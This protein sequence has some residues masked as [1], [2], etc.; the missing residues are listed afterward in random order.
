MSKI[1]AILSLVLMTAAIAPGGTVT[2]RDGRT[3]SGEIRIEGTDLIVRGSGSPEQPDV[4]IPLANVTRAVFIDDKPA[5][6]QAVTKDLYPKPTPRKPA[7]KAAGGITAEY[8]ADAEMKDLRLTR[9]EENMVFAWPAG[10]APDPAVP[11]LFAARWSGRFTMPRYEEA[12]VRTLFV[13]VEGGGLRFWLN[14]KLEVDA[15]DRT[16]P[17]RTQYELEAGQIHEFK[18]EFRRTSAQAD[19]SVLFLMT[20][21]D[22]ET[23]RALKGWYFT[24]A[25]S[26]NTPPQV[27]VNSPLEGD[28]CSTATPLTIEA[29]AT[30]ADGTVKLVRL[31]DNGQLVATLDKPPY[32]ATVDHPKPGLHRLLALAV[33]D[34]G[35]TATSAPVTIHVPAPLG[36]LRS[37]LPAATA[38]VAMVDASGAAGRGS[39]A[40]PADAQHWSWITVAPPPTPRPLVDKRGN[41]DLDAVKAQSQAI[42][43]ASTVPAGAGATFA[44]GRLT[45][46]HAG[47]D[48]RAEA[49]GFGCVFTETE[50]DFQLT[51]RL[52]SFE[53]TD[54]E[55]APLAGL[56]I[57]EDFRPDALRANLVVGFAQKE[58]IVIQL[59]RNQRKT[60]E[61]AQ[62]TVKIPAWLRLI[63]AGRTLRTFSSTDGQHWTPVSQAQ[64]SLPSRLRVGFVACTRDPKVSV[65]AVF[66]HIAL[67]PWQPTFESQATGLLLSSGSFLDAKLISLSSATMDDKTL[68]L[69]L[70]GRKE[71]I[72][73]ARSRIARI[74]FAPL[75]ADAARALKPG[76]VGVLT[77]GGDF[78]DC[79]IDSLASGRLKTRSVLF[80]PKTFRTDTE[81]AAAILADPARADRPPDGAA[82][83]VTTTDGSR[84]FSRSL[85]AEPGQLCV[86]E[87][88][89]GPLTLPAATLRDLKP[90]GGP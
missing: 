48:L 79:S 30:H 31:Y 74:L 80:G 34:K 82:F 46:T 59:T 29:A 69:R 86:D 54:P 64:I 7:R 9:R 11:A 24:P 43:S 65:T 12:K 8:F 35:L 72:S 18:I 19:A 47:G 55:A 78:L 14:G 50:G 28:A 53:C 3:L 25:P 39:Q 84:L 81:L 5:S 83:L 40:R 85:R 73:I 15:W 58:P 32:R 6:T 75:T 60:P 38:P 27:E 36:D 90:L 21:I 42:A 52:A 51:A 16:D 67:A 70:P 76:S 17:T 2:T 71:P 56:V 20:T 89:L 26:D 13:R 66:D 41:F 68:R 77:S 10:V 45:L 61:W 49:D 4:K 63:R 88:D 1:L 62:S 44:D 37:S 23:T 57:Q 87:P 22:R 33:D